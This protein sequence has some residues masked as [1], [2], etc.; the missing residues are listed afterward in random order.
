MELA[1]YLTWSRSSCFLM[2][3]AGE[4]QN[5]DPCFMVNLLS[6]TVL[7]VSV[8]CS[9]MPS[10]IL[11]YEEHTQDPWNNRK[12]IQE[13]KNNCHKTQAWRMWNGPNSIGGLKKKGFVYSFMIKQ[14]SNCWTTGQ[15]LRCVFL[16]KPSS[17]QL[18]FKRSLTL[19]LS[20]NIIGNVIYNSSNNFQ[21]H[22]P[23]APIF[24]FQ[25][26]WSFSQQKPDL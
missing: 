13:E 15:S 18:V 17:H 26:L 19:Y 1:C 9:V 4:Q 2:D 12:S 8:L 10:S 7:S 25:L 23:H 22:F 6:Y 20:R 5:R 24:S 3:T 11:I 14:Q 21:K 16:K